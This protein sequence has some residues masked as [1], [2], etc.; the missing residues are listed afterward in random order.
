MYFAKIA[1]LLVIAIY[2][3]WLN[4]C[5]ATIK[6]SLNNT[7]VILNENL[8]LSC[9]TDKNPIIVT[10]V[11]DVQVLAGCVGYNGYDGYC[12]S[13]TGYL[14]GQVT[15]VESYQ[16]P[17]ICT[18]E[19]LGS[20]ELNYRAAVVVVWEFE[21][22]FEESVFIVGEKVTAY[23]FVNYT[24]DFY[25]FDA[26]Q[27]L[28][29][30]D[31]VE[32]ELNAPTGY[33]TISMEME[34]P[35]L[36]TPLE[37]DCTLGFRTT[38]FKPTSRISDF[39]DST[40]VP[41]RVCSTK[42]TEFLSCFTNVSI[43]PPGGP[44]L[45]GTIF[46]CTAFGGNPTPNYKW[47]ESVTGTVGYGPTFELPE[48]GPE[49]NY[50]YSLTC[51]ADI[52]SIPNCTDS[53]TVE[54]NYTICSSNATIFRVN[55][56]GTRERVDSDTEFFAGDVLECD[57]NGYPVSVI[58]W[59]Y[60]NV[61]VPQVTTDDQ[62]VLD[63]VGKHTVECVANQNIRLCDSNSE[64]ITAIVEKPCFV[65]A[66]ILIPGDDDHT[67]IKV[68]DPVFCLAYNLSGV[69]ENPSI[70]YLWQ[71]GVTGS[72]RTIPSLPLELTCYIL[73]EGGLCND[74]AII[75]YNETTTSVITTKTTTTPSD[76][77]PSTGPP[78]ICICTPCPTCA[79]PVT[80]VTAPDA[81]SCP[82]CE[83]T[84][85]QPCDTTSCPPCDTVEPWT[86]STTPVADQTTPLNCNSTCPP[87]DC[88]DCC[89]L[90]LIIITSLLIALLFSMI[91]GWCLYN[92]CWPFVA[93]LADDVCS[94]Y[95]EEEEEEVE[96]VCEEQYI[97]TTSPCQP[98]TLRNRL[99]PC[100][101]PTMYT[102]GYRF[103]RIPF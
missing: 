88:D 54:G 24:T 102:P 25:N 87:S 21:C 40:N 18:D 67:P 4:G 89:C 38:N 70:T 98:P 64:I 85:N 100:G 22:G 44:V 20:V 43:T 90:P 9:S 91:F 52:N 96:D 1:S 32:D 14:F 75:T 79:P 27:G 42:R 8:T 93:A 45:F 56:D 15:D 16:G 39:V 68:G 80:D 58:N 29:F 53:V 46:T 2:L 92:C 33:Q 94:E 83:C 86:G 84:S 50:T 103:Q 26:T 59:K 82:P 101:D 72:M 78:D 3:S 47:V 74:T 41:K 81:T 7:I 77:P 49:Y 73:V 61:S 60:D 69:G 6:T 97:H 99:S 62:F 5:H 12:D 55:S 65:D 66:I 37:F 36:G 23:C 19:A 31:N 11:H 17:Y 76:T 71:D 57:G 48:T 95:D 28:T 63:E 51:T 13:E 30:D 34:V 35:E 10:I